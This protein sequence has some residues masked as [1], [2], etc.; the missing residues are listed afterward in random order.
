MAKHGMSRLP[1]PRN[2]AR[3]GPGRVA[4]QKRSPQRDHGLASKKTK[5][6]AP[7]VR[8]LSLILIVVVAFGAGFAVRSQTTLLSKLGFNVE[9]SDD[10]STG[11]KEP[12]KSTF[13]SVAMR[14]SEGEDVLFENS[15]DSWDLE[16]A[17]SRVFNAITE[18]SGDKYLTYFDVDR[19]AAYVQESTQGAYAGIGVLFSEYEGRAYVI[20]VFDGSVAAA[21]GVQQGDFVVAID[22]DNSHPWS[23]SEV[24]TSLARNEGDRVVVTWMRPTSLQAETGEEFTTT[25]VCSEYAVENVSSQLL[26]SIGYIRLRQIT[27]NSTELVEA[28]VKE[29]AEAGAKAFVLDIRDNPGGYL[30]QAVNI[31]SLF[32]K[33]GVLV[34][35]ETNEGITN[36]TASGKV[37]TTLPLVVL[38]NEHTSA[39]AEVLAAALQDNGR[40]TIVGETTFGKGSVQVMRELSFGGAIRYT[41]AYYRTPLGHDINYVG[42]IPDVSIGMS[43]EETL[44]TQKDMALETARSLVQE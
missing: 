33:S 14:L 22:G 42:I 5:E 32:V 41:A 7:L 15:M 24:V 23:M 1:G 3:R 35:I 27:Q 40:A 34:E 4:A 16:D 2:D 13:D 26:D 19:Y 28:A 36:K 39:A 29:L 6:N 17:T 18:A 8:V 11:S 37:A 21:N 43:S 44:D 10:G 9:S 20:D 30:T 25:L 12:S 38:V 31:A